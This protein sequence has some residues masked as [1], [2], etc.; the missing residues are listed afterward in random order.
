[1]VNTIPLQF[2]LFFSLLLFFVSLVG[3]VFN[4]DN[5]IKTLV[6]A[7]LL[8]FAISFNYISISIYTYNPEGQ[9]IAMF[10]TCLAASESVLGLGLLILNYKVRNTSSLSAISRLKR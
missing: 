2:C 3:F 4:T 10:I 6:Y 7:E 8:L 9:I 5:F 1:M